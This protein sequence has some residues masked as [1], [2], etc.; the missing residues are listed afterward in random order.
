MLERNPQMI[1]NTM[2]FLPAEMPLLWFHRSPLRWGMGTF[3]S[4]CHPLFKEVVD[5]SCCAEQCTSIMGTLLTLMSAWH[6]FPYYREQERNNQQYISKHYLHSLHIWHLKSE[7]IGIMF[8]FFFFLS[9]VVFLTLCTGFTAR[10]NQLA[11]GNTDKICSNAMN[12]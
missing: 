11:L 3:W 1:E 12:S 5:C 9:K 8:F 7:E 6:N 2:G 10:K 4:K